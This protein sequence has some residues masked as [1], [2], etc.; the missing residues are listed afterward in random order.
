MSDTVILQK[1]DGVWQVVYAQLNK[2]TAWQYEK[3][4]YGGVPAPGFK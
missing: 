3:E 4:N 2:P 1:E